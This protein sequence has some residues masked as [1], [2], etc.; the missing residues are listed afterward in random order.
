MFDVG[1]M[2]LIRCGSKSVVALQGLRREGQETHLKDERSHILRRGLGDE[3]GDG[4][5]RRDALGS[6]RQYLQGEECSVLVVAASVLG[7]IPVE[8]TLLGFAISTVQRSAR[9]LRKQA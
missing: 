6:A 8:G 9:S 2:I 7:V 3:E 4:G 5:R 1:C